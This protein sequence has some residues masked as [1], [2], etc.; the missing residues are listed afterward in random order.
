MKKDWF[1]YKGRTPEYMFP[2]RIL[3]SNG[4]SRTD[5]ETF[6]EEELIDAGYIKCTEPPI[7]DV[8]K[9]ILLYD[10]ESNQWSVQPAT[11]KWIAR[12][13]QSNLDSL[14]NENESHRQLL[15]SEFVWRIYRNQSELRLGLTPT[16]DIQHLLAY[17]D[18][19]E[20]LDVSSDPYNVVWPERVI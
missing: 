8:S 9:E 11:E 5:P 17:R 16:E 6:T 15:L 18:A 7:Y 3:L 14:A 12:Y 13:N 19:L 1:S 20:S 4:D 10:P 2:E